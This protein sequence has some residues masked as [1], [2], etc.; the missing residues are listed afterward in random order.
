MEYALEF[1]DRIVALRRGQVFFD[2]HPNA[3]DDATQV[4][5]YELAKPEH[6]EQVAA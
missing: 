5:L 1:A 6:L 4:A 2:G 3:M